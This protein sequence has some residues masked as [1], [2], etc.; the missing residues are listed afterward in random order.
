MEYVSQL[1]ELCKNSY[2]TSWAAIYK[3]FGE[4]DWAIYVVGKPFQYTTSETGEAAGLKSDLN[5]CRLLSGP[6]SSIL[7][8]KPVS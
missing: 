7:S 1:G 5:I 6:I 8:D 2:S 3:A 4:N